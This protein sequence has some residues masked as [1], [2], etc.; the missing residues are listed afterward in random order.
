[1]GRG[2]IDRDDGDA[3]GT[4]TVDELDRGPDRVAER[5]AHAGPEEGVDDDGS[6]LDAL[7]EHRDVAGDRGVDLGDA[8]VAG[9]AIP[10]AG[11]GRSPGSRLARDDRDDDLGAGERQAT[12]RDEAV[13]AV[14]AWSAQDDDG[15]RPPTAGID[16]QRAD[17]G[18]D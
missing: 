18:R 6:A 8:G 13:P 15:P 10:V 7:S 16:G 3:A 5:A 11:G 17:R 12:C 9:D 14:V 1:D 2:R 4:G